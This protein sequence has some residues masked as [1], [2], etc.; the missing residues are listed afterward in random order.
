MYRIYKISTVGAIF[1]IQD[2]YR[3]LYSFTYRS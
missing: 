3:I 2:P 1:E